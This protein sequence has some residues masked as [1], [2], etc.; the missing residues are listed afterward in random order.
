MTREIL[1][2]RV[3]VTEQKVKII[4]VLIGETKAPLKESHKMKLTSV[5]ERI[6]KLYLKTQNT[7][8]SEE[9]IQFVNE[10]C[11]REEHEVEDLILEMGLI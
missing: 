1:K 6:K 9:T 2:K 5:R 11:Q 3:A 7:L 4:E 10:L 8:I